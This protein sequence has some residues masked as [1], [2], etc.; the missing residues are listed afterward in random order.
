MEQRNS[1]FVGGEGRGSGAK[2]R[3]HAVDNLIL[4]EDN[5]AIDAN[6]S[7]ISANFAKII[8]S[9]T[10]A[11]TSATTTWTMDDSNGS[12]KTTRRSM[13]KSSMIIL[14]ASSLAIF[15]GRKR[16]KWRHKPRGISGL[17]GRH[18]WKMEGS[19]E[20]VGRSRDKERERKREKTVWKRQ[21]K[22]KR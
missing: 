7:R 20:K 11:P 14:R 1:H 13:I 22:R 17:I 19:E 3:R 8:A 16:H 5:R 12:W 15:I 2:A 4:R 9:Q 10:W 6:E 18:R 21:R